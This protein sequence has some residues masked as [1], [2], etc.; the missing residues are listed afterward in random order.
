MEIDRKMSE[1][2]WCFSEKLRNN[3]GLNV[4]FS[5]PKLGGVRGGLNTL[6]PCLNLTLNL[7]LNLSL[8][9]ASDDV[10]VQTPSGSP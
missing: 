8:N 2:C 4:T 7:S 10:L 9:L 6:R 1:R 5:P 3:I